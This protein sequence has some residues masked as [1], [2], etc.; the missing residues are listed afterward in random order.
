MCNVC[1]RVNVCV[2]VRERERLC[3]CGFRAN[4]ILLKQEKFCCKMSNFTSFGHVQPKQLGCMRIKLLVEK[5]KYSFGQ[6]KHPK[7]TKIQ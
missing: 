5:I 6:Q 1:M 7:M 4:Q 2:C 3:V